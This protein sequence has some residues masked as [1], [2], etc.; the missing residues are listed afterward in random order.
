VHLAGVTGD[1]TLYNITGSVTGQW[2]TS[3]P[4]NTGFT[5]TRF[6]SAGALAAQGIFTYATQRLVDIMTWA[7]GVSIA[8]VPV[9]FVLS[10][11]AA[12]QF[13]MVRHA[14]RDVDGSG[15]E[16]LPLELVGG[17]AQ[18][19]PRSLRFPERRAVQ[20]QRLRGGAA[21]GAE[22]GHA[23]ELARPDHGYVR[24]K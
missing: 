4:T 7:P 19:L 2:R 15:L 11:G 5:I 22:P 18:Q 14:A 1:A 20:R 3:L 16:F 6:D 9:Y 24:L 17:R 10:N 13:D 12:S 23:R 21:K 8:N